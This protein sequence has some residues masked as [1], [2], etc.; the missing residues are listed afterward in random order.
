KLVTNNLIQEGTITTAPS[1]GETPSSTS[2]T[3]KSTKRSS[4]RYISASTTAPQSFDTYK[5]I[6]AKQAASYSSSAI[7]DATTGKYLVQVM[8]NGRVPVNTLQTLLQT[9]Y[10]ELAVQAV[11]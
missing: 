3:T 7:A 1:V 4:A 10:S 5:A 2:T 8:P 9:T 6:I 11:D